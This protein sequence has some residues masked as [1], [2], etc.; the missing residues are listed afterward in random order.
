MKGGLISVV[1]R[2]LSEQETRMVLELVEWETFVA[3]SDQRGGC[4]PR[5]SY[6]NGVLEMMNNKREHENRPSNWPVD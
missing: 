6:N 3:L 4:V 5:M 2:V 1:E